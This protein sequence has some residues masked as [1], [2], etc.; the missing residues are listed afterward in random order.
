MGTR[1]IKPLST[2]TGQLGSSSKYW[3]KGYINELYVNE[4]HTSSSSTLSANGISVTSSAGIIFEGSAADDHE[5]QLSVTNPSGDRIITFPDA[6]GTVALT[7]DVPT[8]E[9][10]QDIVGAMFSSNTETNITATYEDGDGTIDLVSVN[11]TYSAGTGIDLST[12]TFN[13]DLTEVIAADAENCILTTDG[14]GTLTSESKWSI[15]GDTLSSANAT[16]S[17]ACID[18][19][20]SGLTTGH[21]LRI[22]DDTYERAAG[23]IR[24]D[25]TDTYVSTINRGN[26]GL[27]NIQ[28]NRPSANNVLGAQSLTTWGSTIRMDD[29]AS[30]HFGDA[31]M[32][33]QQIWVDYANSGTGNT[34]AVGLQ[35]R[36]GGGDTNV[37]IKM[38]N[39]ADDSEY[40]TINVGAGGGATFQ[41]YSD[42]ETG[43]L[44][45]L[46]D[47]NVKISSFSDSSSTGTI[48]QNSGTTIADLTVH[49]SATW[50]TIYENGGASTDDYFTIKTQAKGAT[51]LIT[52]DASGSEEAHLT[53]DAEGVINL[54][55]DGGA[56][57]FKDDSAVL[58]K[59]ST[60]GLDFTD[61]IGAKIIFEG[62]TDDAHQTTLGVTE[63]TQD[64]A[65]ELPNAAGTVQ[66]QGTSAGKQLQIFSQSFGDDL[67]T[68]KHYLPFKDINEQ[69]TIY[70]EEAAMI[71]PAD[72]RIVSVTI[73]MSQVNAGANRTIGVHTFGP[74][75]S[76]FTTGNWTE[77][78]TETLAI[79]SSDD[80]HVFHFAFSNAKHF[81]SGELV[82]LSIQDDSDV[83]SGWRYTYVSTVV[84]WDYSTW[85]GSTSLETDAAI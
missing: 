22:T 28:Y 47:G 19:T 18:I 76:Q 50:L 62:G 63:P 58:A 77:E 59:I 56:I 52:W 38:I 70:Q 35:T 80:N 12:T 71:A 17:G 13:L 39:D 16:T 7:S 3:N 73:R 46:A 25:I 48:F 43:D 85:L 82:T 68:T 74:N 1:T 41:T 57:I 51:D 64:N 67:G 66:L 4:L 40:T 78:E 79:S 26:Y 23:H 8:T 75:A 11:T 49:H 31:S 37:D 53:L 33:G 15:D 55:A 69:T 30:D 54:D 83:H 61:N 32:I 34:T 60:D 84:E 5:L 10:I 44:R 42:D 27:M 14:D 24:L 36:V 20:A 45:F 21:G 65:I 6:S 2:N 72:G 9:S 29:N 81:E